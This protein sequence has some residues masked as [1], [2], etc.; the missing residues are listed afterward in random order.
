MNN[1]KKVY[2]IIVNYKKWEDTVECLE[3]ILHNRYQSCQTIVCDN[4][5]GD[6]SLDKIRAWA[7]GRLS[8]SVDAANPLKHLT[9]PPA[10]KPVPYAFYTRKDLEYPV[11]QPLSGDPLI[12][13]DSETNLGFAGGNNVG[14]RFAQLKNDF[15]YI[16][17]LNNDTVIEPDALE[18]LVL[19]AQQQN[20]SGKKTGVIGSKLLYYDRPDIIQAAGG[21][22]YKTLAYS[23]HIGSGKP[24]NGQF[25][26]ENLKMDYIIGASML[27]S[28][29]FID[30]VGPM[31]EDYFIYFEETDW[32][33]RGKRKGWEI[34]YAWKSRVYHKE[35]AS[36]GA[37]TQKRTKSDLAVYFFFRN[38]LL[39]TKRYHPLLL[40]TLIPRIAATFIYRV[41]SG[42]FRKAGAMLKAV[43]GRKY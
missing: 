2:I 41:C 23:R 34:A 31:S 27:V 40:T 11:T 10:M 29:E 8:H 43:T 20:S 14:F 18:Q 19:Q 22:Y 38:A 4:G 3:S 28:K 6:G 42:D 24:D 13:I 17:F 9:D 33:T 16:W 32:I 36:I 39:F 5:S 1:S 30:D 25:D 7:E 37:N 15:S 21:I 12:I 35:G 26:D